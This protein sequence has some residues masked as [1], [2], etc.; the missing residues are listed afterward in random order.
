MK[1]NNLGK[2]IL[3]DECQKITM[4]KYLSL[5]RLKMK[6]SLLASELSVF[7]TPIGFTTSCTGFGGTR[8]WFTCPICNKRKGVLF[9][10]PINGNVGCRACL[11]L[12]YRVQ[13]F[14]GMIE[15]SK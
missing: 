4:N 5:A 12:K 7:T 8:H 13:R 9:V 6:E 3:V 10:H 1:P 14:K 15:G 2:T 11:E